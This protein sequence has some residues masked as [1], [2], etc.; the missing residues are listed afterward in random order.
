[1]LFQAVTHSL[2]ELIDCPRRPGYTNDRHVEMAPPNHRLQRRK[3]F[4]ESQITGCSVEDQ[5]VRVVT[6]HGNAPLADSDSG[7]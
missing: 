4:L 5:G 3:D 1:M 2:P 7:G 6:A